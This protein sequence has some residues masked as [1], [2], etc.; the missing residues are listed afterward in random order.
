MTQHLNRFS[1]MFFR[2]LLYD[3]NPGEGFNLRRD[4]YM[5]IATLVKKLNKE[6]KEKEWVLVLPPWGPLYHW[7]TKNI[8]YQA[9]V[10]WSNFFDIPSLRKYVPVMELQDFL[11]GKLG[12]V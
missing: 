6:S 11:H 7:K 5:R 8:G 1:F 2:Y 4:V 10:N 9:Q 3:V 12:F